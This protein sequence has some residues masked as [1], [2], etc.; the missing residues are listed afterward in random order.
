MAQNK[1]RDIGRQRRVSDRAEDFCA[2]L[3]FGADDTARPDRRLAE[4]RGEDMPGR[5]SGDRRSVRVTRSTGV[6]V[7]GGQTRAQRS[8]AAKR[9]WETRRKN[10]LKRQG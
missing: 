5:A 6:R 7:S 4:D 2:D 10:A 8:A 3:G 9:G 1:G